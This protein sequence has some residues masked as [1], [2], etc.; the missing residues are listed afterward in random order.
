MA[1]T[2]RGLGN[3]KAIRLQNGCDRI[4]RD[5][6]VFQMKSLK[7]RARDL[8]ATTLMPNHDLVT[9]LFM[10][11]HITTRSASIIAPIVTVTAPI[12]IIAI[13]ITT[14]ADAV[15]VTAVRYGAV[16]LSK[17]DF[18]SGR[19]SISS[20]SAGRGESPRCAHNG[21]D[22]RQSHSDLLL[23]LTLQIKVNR[24]AARLFVR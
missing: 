1:R 11:L 14:L 6:W 7:P 4:Q 13:V 19:D 24:N 18:G 16:Q 3:Q 21:G 23:P 2:S 22:K 9:A 12:V 10:D 8:V 5:L 15:S 17:H 20:I